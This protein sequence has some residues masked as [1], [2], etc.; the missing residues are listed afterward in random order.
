[1]SRKDGIYPIPN[2]IIDDLID[3]KMILPNNKVWVREVFCDY[4]MGYPGKE[5]IT[6]ICELRTQEYVTPDGLHLSPLERHLLGWKKLDP[7][8][9]T[10][11]GPK[12]VPTY[13]KKMGENKF[14]LAFVL[15]YN[16][17]GRRDSIPDFMSAI[18]NYHY[19]PLTDIDLED[20][21]N[22][23]ILENQAI[24][25]DTIREQLKGEWIHE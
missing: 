21:M 9:Y 19:T 20:M 6:N 4:S 12:D 15:D 22:K 1:M 13:Y 11:G 5:Y 3:K 23:A 2:S 7:I 17:R 25:A 24:D 18:I 8:E 14:Y 16:P 10:D